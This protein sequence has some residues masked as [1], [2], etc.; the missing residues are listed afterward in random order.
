MVTMALIITVPLSFFLGSF[1]AVK[2]LQLGLRWRAQQEAHEQ[3]TVGNP[4]GAAYHAAFDATRDG[5]ARRLAE[6]Q[7]KIL[8]E[9]LNGPSLE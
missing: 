9:Y 7:A 3:P 5:R 1:T 8:N 2:C 6:D 4:L